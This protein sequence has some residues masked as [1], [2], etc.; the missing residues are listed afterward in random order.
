MQ[1]SLQDLNENLQRKS[2][3]TKLKLNTEEAYTQCVSQLL[4]IQVTKD[5]IENF[6]S[7]LN[8]RVLVLYMP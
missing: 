8:L 5:L 3:K 2:N 4:L 1:V 7:K 6:A